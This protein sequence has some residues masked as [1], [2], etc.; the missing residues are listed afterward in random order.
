MSKTNESL[1]KLALFKV[2]MMFTLTSIMVTSFDLDDYD[3][4]AGSAPTK[5]FLK[6]DQL[7]IKCPKNNSAVYE[8]REP[9]KTP[10]LRDYDYNVNKDGDII[11]EG[12]MLAH[13]Y[14]NTINAKDYNMVNGLISETLSRYMAECY[15]ILYDLIKQRTIETPNSSCKWYKFSGLLRNSVN[16]DYHIGWKD[17]SEIYYFGGADH[18]EYEGASIAKN[19]KGK[20][21]IGDWDGFSHWLMLKLAKEIEDFI[22]THMQA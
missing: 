20:H 16:H 4:E 17:S 10:G 15:E 1:K 18:I 13:A 9:T 11:I 5:G 14:A 8:D 12:H 3:P 22:R 6:L 19:D 21:F 2:K 7:L